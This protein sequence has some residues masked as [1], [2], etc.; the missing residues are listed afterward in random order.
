M[1]QDQILLLS[2]SCI[3]RESDILMYMKVVKVPVSSQACKMCLK[4]PGTDVGAAGFEK[5]SQDF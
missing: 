4:S 2:H 1:L 5:V 3:H